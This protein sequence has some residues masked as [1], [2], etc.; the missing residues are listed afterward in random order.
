MRIVGLVCSLLL[1]MPVLGQDEEQ[2]WQLNARF[3][4]SFNEAG[5]ILKAEPSLGYAVNRHFEI[6]AALPVYFVKNSTT[7]LE[8]GAGNAALGLV[9]DFNSPIL[10]YNS[11]VVV[12]APTGDRDKGFS[13]G[14]VT[15]DWTN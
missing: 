8:G 14:H 1:A 15:A 2:R 3:Q 9:M 11:T 4:G 10:H 13:T 12:T 7:S 5:Q 6:Y